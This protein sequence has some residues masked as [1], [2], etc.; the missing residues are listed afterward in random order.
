LLAICASLICKTK[1]LSLVLLVVCALTIVFGVL[2]ACC[3]TLFAAFNLQKTELAKYFAVY[4]IRGLYF[5]IIHTASSFV[6]V[7]LLYPPLVAVLK[8]IRRQNVLSV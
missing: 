2:S 6:T 5:D 4:Y 7:L 1:K 8:S 3:D